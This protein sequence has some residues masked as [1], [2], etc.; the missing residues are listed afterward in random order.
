MPLDVE[1]FEHLLELKLNRSI[2]IPTLANS[3]FMKSNEFATDA[4]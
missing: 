1:H 3:D 2:C 4:I